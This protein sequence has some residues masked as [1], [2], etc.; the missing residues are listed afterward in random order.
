MMKLSL[1]EDE[2]FHSLLNLILSDDPPRMD[3]VMEIK[4]ECN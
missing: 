2:L 1:P 4:S 3:V